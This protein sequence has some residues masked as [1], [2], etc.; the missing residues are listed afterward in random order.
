ME[1]LSLI[2]IDK[3]MKLNK[4]VIRFSFSVLMQILLIILRPLIPNFHFF[5]IIFLLALVVDC[6]QVLKI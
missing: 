4:K 2:G 6:L 3:H 1:I 5:Y